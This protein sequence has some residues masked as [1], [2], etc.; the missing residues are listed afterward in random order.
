MIYAT[1]AYIGRTN[2]YLEKHKAFAGVDILIV[3]PTSF[4]NPIYLAVY[5]NTILGLWQAEKFASGSA[6]RHIYPRDVAQFIISLPSED[7]QSKI[8]NLVIQ[9]YETRKKA[10]I[11]LEE[12]KKKVEEMIEKR[13]KS[14]D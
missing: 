1:G 7:L 12:A 13:N 14:N 2:C 9:S 4:C 8:A 10:K 3:R 5:L 11:L 6:Q